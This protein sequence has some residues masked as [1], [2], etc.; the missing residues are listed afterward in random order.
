MNLIW[1]IILVSVTLKCWIGQIIIAFTPKIA[2]KIKIIEPKSYMD[3]TFFL[4]MH[5]TAIWDAI[6]LWTLP[7]AGILL[8]L[9]NTL[10]TYFGLIGG[11]MYL[12]FVGRG[13][14]SCLTMQR[15]GIKIG[16]SK[17]LKVKYMILTL[18]GFIAIVTIIMAIATLTL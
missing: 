15:H 1:G 12:Y 11:G 16:R 8:I 4:D 10:W 9:N 3:P 13:I 5:G 17:K 7:L 18:W 2:E 14:A 6:S